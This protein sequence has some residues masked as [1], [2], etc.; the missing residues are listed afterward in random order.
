M[1]PLQLQAW[2]GAIYQK[3]SSYLIN[4]ADQ[5]FSYQPVL[6]RALAPLVERWGTPVLHALSRLW[7][8][9]AEDRRRPLPLPDPPARKVQWE[10]SLD[11]AS[12]SLSLEPLGYAWDA[13]TQV[14]GRA[15]GGRGVVGGGARRLAAR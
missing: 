15:R 6:S 11:E 4:L 13:V 10:H 12:V 1:A 14:L 7:Q 2:S 9:E 8:I 5:L 3:L